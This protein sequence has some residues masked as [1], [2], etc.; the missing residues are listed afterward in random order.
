MN[1][2]LGRLG[3]ALALASLSACALQKPA[4]EA[5]PPGFVVDRVAPGRLAV[6][7]G[8][9]APAPEFNQYAQGKGAMASASASELAGKA[10]AVGAIAPRYAAIRMPLLL[11]VVPLMMPFT[12]VGGAVGGGVVGAVKGAWNGM[13]GDQVKAIH[14]P[15]AR[16]LHDEALQ[17]RLA[18]QTVSAAN[19]WPLYRAEQ[20]QVASNAK[21]APSYDELKAE[22]FG[23]VLEVQAATIGFDAWKS[24]PPSASFVMT[25]HARSVVFDN[26]AQAKEW[27]LSYRGEARPVAGWS[28]NGAQLLDEELAAAGADLAGQLAEAALWPVAE[29]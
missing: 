3:A 5:A 12:I 6:V 21:A 24:E 18:A 26:R 10:A 16:A 15:V 9:R 4:E 7:A 22:G 13:P 17:Q 27:T 20:R 23:A 19:E 2:P 8:S 29:E 28:A 1:Y 11:P 14:E 25:V